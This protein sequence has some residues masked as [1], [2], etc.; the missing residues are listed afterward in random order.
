[1]LEITVKPVNGVHVVA[2]RGRMDATTTA[3][4]E[5]T[6]LPLME[7][8]CRVVLD[9]T[10]L[11]YLSSAGLRTLLIVYRGGQ[12]AGGQMALAGVSENLKDT[13][14]MTGFLPH[15]EVYDTLD[16]A[17]VALLGASE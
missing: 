16:E 2:L 5:A 15:F 10:A 11:K 1:M 12:D 7:P 8:E 9:M 17:L 14:E 13:M 6:V 3:E 4:V